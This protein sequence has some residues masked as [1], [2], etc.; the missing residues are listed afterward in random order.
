MILAS[1]FLKWCQIFKIPINGG[2]G[3]GDGSPRNEII[4]SSSVIDGKVSASVPLFTTI[5]N[6]FDFFIPDSLILV[7]TLVTAAVGPVALSVGSNASSYDNLLSAYDFSNL[8]LTGNSQSIPFGNSQWL[9]AGAVGTTLQAKITGVA[10]GTA[11]SLI[12]L[13][14]CIGIKL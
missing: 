8:N 13:L 5:N 9:T 14:K 2:G 11:F 3:G 12:I 1:D 10:V 6:N 7:P 4:F